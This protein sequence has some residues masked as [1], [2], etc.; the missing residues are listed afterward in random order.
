MTRAIPT[1]ITINPDSFVVGYRVAEAVRFDEIVE[2]DLF[3][4]DTGDIRSEVHYL[5]DGRD[6]YWTLYEDMLG[7]W[8]LMRRLASLPGGVGDLQKVLNRS[9]APW[10]VDIYRR[11]DPGASFGVGDPAVAPA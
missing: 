11:P 8:D 7:F 2:A 4:K 1:I 3:E 5:R 9:P 10:L 6:L